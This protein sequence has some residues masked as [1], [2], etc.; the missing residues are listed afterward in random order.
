VNVGLDSNR[1]FRNDWLNRDPF[2]LSGSKSP[3][4]QHMQL[5]TGTKR[6]MKMEKDGIISKI[7]DYKLQ[8]I[9]QRGKPP[10]R[11]KDQFM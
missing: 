8:G 5:N 9:S 11:W 3:Q 10:K 7:L 4:A 2:L 1:D 6:V